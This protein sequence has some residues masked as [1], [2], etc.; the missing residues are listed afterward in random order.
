MIVKGWPKF[1]LKIE[2]MRIEQQTVRFGSVADITARLRH[3]RFTP[4]SGHSSVKVG[5]PQS[6]N[7]GHSEL[8]VS[9]RS[10]VDSSH[11]GHGIA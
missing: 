2:G 10:M 1:G 7:R 4:D 11:A 3:V 8:A 6:A 5:C 9:T